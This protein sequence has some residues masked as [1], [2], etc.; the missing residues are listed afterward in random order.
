M[1]SG[2]HIILRRKTRD[3]G[4]F[5]ISFS[6]HE[7]LFCVRDGV[8]CGAFP[9]R[10]RCGRCSSQA[11]AGAQAV[12]RAALE[13]AREQRGAPGA[14]GRLFGGAEG[15]P[16]RDRGAAGQR[17]QAH[18]PARRRP[19]SLL[20]QGQRGA[21]RRARDAHDPGARP[22]GDGNAAVQGERSFF[23]G[24]DHRGGKVGQ[25]GERNGEPV[26]KG[27][28]RPGL[29]RFAEWERHQGT[30]RSRERFHPTGAGRPPATRFADRPRR[31]DRRPAAAA[32]GQARRPGE[33]RCRSDQ[34]LPAQVRRAGHRSRQCRRRVQEVAR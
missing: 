30:R 18:R 5:A 26:S 17:P 4:G 27:E 1:T 14:I 6:C 32:K 8:G 34:G 12:T 25:P 10:R 23:R 9:E 28:P 11:E 31:E 20:E 19:A 22:E 21:G 13:T 29:R 3:F 16:G 7:S 24:A 2:A 15:V 33:A